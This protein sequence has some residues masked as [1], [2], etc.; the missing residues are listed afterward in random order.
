MFA[1]KA[2]ATSFE[3][4]SQKPVDCLTIEQNGT[5]FHRFQPTYNLLERA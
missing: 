2:I 1:S 4:T 5:A 3:E